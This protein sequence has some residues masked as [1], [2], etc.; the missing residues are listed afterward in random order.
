[1]SLDISLHYDPKLEESHDF[2]DVARAFEQALVAILLI[3]DEYV[4]DIDLLSPQHR[5]TLFERNRT[6]PVVI[7]D[8]LHHLIEKSISKNPDS[9]A[10]LS[11][12]GF[13]TYAELDRLSSRLAHHL[14]NIY[15]LSPER[16]VPLCFEKSIWAV[17]AMLAVLKTGASYCCLDPAHPQARRNH[18]IELVD[19]DVAL[20]SR[21]HVNLIRGCPALIIDGDLIYH[22][23]TQ[24]TTPISGVEPK[25]TC[26]VLFTSGTTGNPKA[27]VHSHISLCSGLLANAPFQGINRSSVRLFQWAAY[28]FDVSITEIFSPLIYGGVVCIPSEE[29]R[30]NNVEECMMRMSVDWA[31][32]TPTFAR[33]FRRYNIPSLKQLILGG[34]AVTV[35][36]VRD[37]VERVQVLNAY[38][39]A[40]SITW[41]LE[42][43]QGLSSIISIGTPINMCGWIVSPDDPAR[44]MPIGAVGELLLEGPSLFEKYLKN[45]EKT[46]QSLIDP[47]PWRIQGGIGRASKMYKTGDLVHYL[48]NGT[49]TYVGRKDTLVKLY[50]QRMELA[51]VET[52]LRRYLPD[53]VQS[54]ADV[55]RPAGVNEE[56]LLVAF[57]CSPNGFKDTSLQELKIHLQNKLTEVLPPFMIPRIFVPVESMPYNSSRK[58]DRGK[59]RQY[60]SSLTRSQ[61]VELIQANSSPV[62]DEGQDLSH[63]ELTLQKLWADALLLEA[64]QVGP[65]D[66]FFSLGGSSV[67][68]LNVT[69]AAKLQGVKI[70]YPDLFRAPR[71]R[72]LAQIVYISSNN[73][74]VS[75]SRFGLVES[76]VKAKVISDAVQQCQITE[77]EIEDI[78][79]QAPQQQGLWALSLMQRGDYIAQFILTLNPEVDVEKFCATWETVIKLLPTLRTRFIESVSGSYQVVLRDDV[80]WQLASHLGDYLEKDINIEPGFGLPMVRYALIVER[81]KHINGAVRTIHKVVWTI[82]HA[83]FDGESV[84]LFLNMVAQAYEGILP[85]PETQHF[86]HFIRYTQNL[87]KTASSEYWRSQFDRTNPVAYPLLPE[88]THRPNPSSVYQKHIQYSRCVGSRITTATVF[89]A[90]LALTLVR[91]AQTWDATIG[92]TLAGRTCPVSNIESVIGP[93][94]VTLPTRIYYGPNDTVEDYLKHTQSSIV[95]MMPFEHTGMQKIRQLSP[96][97]DAACQ[98]QTLLLI[99]TPEDRSYE[100]LFTFDDTAGGFGRFNS[101]ALMVLLFPNPYGIDAVFSYDSHVIAEAEV[102]RL[103]YIFEHHIHILCLE[104]KARSIA[105]I[106]AAAPIPK[107]VFHHPKLGVEH[108]SKHALQ[109]FSDGQIGSGD[110]ISTAHQF[111]G[112]EAL[113]AEMWTETLRL[114]DNTVIS[115]HDEFYKTYGGNSLLSMK[116]ARLCRE[117]NIH[118]TVKDI[119]QNPKL[120]D[121]AKAAAIASPATGDFHSIPPFSLLEHADRFSKIQELERIITVRTEAAIACNVLE[122]SV[123]DVYPC[124]PLQEG[125][126][127]LSITQPGSYVSQTVY[128]LVDHIDVGKFRGAWN[129]IY[130]EEEILRTRLVQL[131]SASETFQ[132]VLSNTIEWQFATNLAQYL[133]ENGGMKMEFGTPLNRFAI[134]QDGVR[135][136]VYFVLIIHHALYDGWSMPLMVDRVYQAYFEKASSTKHT[137]FNRFIQK[138]MSI[139]K[140]DSTTYWKSQF[141]NA[142]FA[143]F[144]AQLLPTEKPGRQTTLES[145]ITIPKCQDPSILTSTILRGAWALL[146]STYTRSQDVIFGATLSGRNL[147]LDG[148]EEMIGPT[149]TT[150][151]IR[152]Q[153]DQ[154]EQATDFLHRVQNQSTDMI[155]FE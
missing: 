81:E 107:D 100:K 106:L 22:L 28:T 9:I 32:F 86:N 122:E 124:T 68:A 131:T 133:K 23:D 38:G 137:P 114:P 52:V 3:K 99:Q 75:I 12:D 2:G 119:F 140:S 54:S 134:I 84:P 20:C 33:F 149:L 91:L 77:D 94:F 29:E 90:A 62:Q 144:P 21:I 34:E 35:D 63:M 147:S 143:H 36:D 79:P 115:S 14:I 39:P 93:T 48:P 95:E 148:I 83:L 1:M 150:V 45:K 51:E 17:V 69:A 111:D 123:L 47:P 8:C 6:P 152:I 116:L 78:Y 60:V 27:I 87:D 40:E 97:C 42:P 128:E 145:S 130:K 120:G 118:L 103:A 132:V 49:M 25:N 105:S 76:P 70:S 56:P 10:L 104:E 37:W 67:T 139:Q 7:E 31:Y 155:D 127:A 142:D 136:K 110:A 117:K 66:N 85:D 46:E 129:K 146:L 73:T 18:V 112:M 44:L 24:T 135:S 88:P 71:L 13:L 16:I 92:V 5:T 108:N 72:D 50:G 55:I 30:L 102:S 138:V 53:S 41:F 98:F 58:L 109:R 153:L 125:L 57:L 26:V 61:L 19:A 96:Q 154:T 151:P 126:L 65:D 15:K 82:H 4:A 11:W 59:L 64:R 74:E 141:L 89:R 113:I 43:Q 121:M 80:T 101:H